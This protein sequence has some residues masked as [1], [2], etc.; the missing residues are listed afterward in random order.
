MPF[1]LKFWKPI[2]SIGLGIMIIVIFFFWLSSHDAKVAED[3]VNAHIDKQ[4]IALEKFKKE[5]KKDVKSV[6]ES[7]DA[8]SDESLNFEL[9]GKKS[10]ES[11]N[12]TGETTLPSGMGTSKSDGEG[13]QTYPFV[14]SGD[15]IRHSDKQSE[16]EAVHEEMPEK[17]GLERLEVLKLAYPNVTWECK[18]D[19]LKSGAIRWQMKVFE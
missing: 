6:K 11:E 15:E 2:A 7:V 10:C 17:C 3:A 19:V 12:G 1:L 16:P 14:E 18:E 13:S 9:C 4:R 8:L 5:D